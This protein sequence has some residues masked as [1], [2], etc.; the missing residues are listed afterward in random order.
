MEGDAADAHE[1]EEAAV[2]DLLRRYEAPRLRDLRAVTPAAA[3]K[4]TLVMVLTGWAIG[5]DRMRSQSVDPSLVSPPPRSMR[6]IVPHGPRSAPRATA[7]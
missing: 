1:G 7:G 6:R 3:T 5:P 4:A 2:R